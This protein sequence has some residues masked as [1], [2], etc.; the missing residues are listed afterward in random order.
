M[1]TIQR[2][3]EHTALGWV[4][5]AAGGL[6]LAFVATLSPQ[7]ESATGRPAVR[8][9]VSVPA[10]LEV[11]VFGLFALAALVVLWLLIPR[12]L[13]RRKKDPESFEMV[14]EMP[15]VSPWF[16][17]A[18]LALSAAPL[19]LMGYLLW[20]GWSPFEEGNLRVPPAPGISA[21]AMPPAQGVFAPYASEPWFS[22][23]VTVLALVAGAG[24]LAV[25]LWILF[26]DRMIGSWE[27]LL[28]RSRSP[29][30]LLE[31]IDDSL[32]ALR[33][34]SDARRAIIRCYRRFEHAVTRRGLPRKPWETPMEFMQK[35]LGRL[36]LA[37]DVVK[38]L[39]D[40][41]HLARFSDHPLGLRERDLAVDSLVEIRAALEGERANASAI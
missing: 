3:R 17:V 1:T 11:A 23:A 10:P 41:F 18:M 2:L 7:N 12:G 9:V 16:T 37:P 14:Y 39:I 29:E 31:A 21:P 20:R 33:R 4:I 15:K 26:G 24:C 27:G 32:E 34:E 6:I 8:L 30:P 25:T 40:L 28:A 19:V 22:G 13:R 36:P 5:V 35:A 38:S